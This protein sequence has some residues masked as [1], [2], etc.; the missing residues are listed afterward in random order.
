MGWKLNLRNIGAIAAAPFT[1]GTSLLLAKDTDNNSILNHVTGAASAK[2]ANEQNIALQKETNK[3]SIDLANTAHQREVADLEA[4]GLNPILSAGGSGAATPT[5]GTAQVQNTMPGGLMGQASQAAGILGTIASAKQAASAAELQNAQASAIPSQ[6]KLNQS[7]SA[8]ALA[9]AGYK[10]SEIDYYMEH[11]TFPGQTESDTWSGL[12]F[13]RTK[14][15]PANANSAKSA[16]TLEEKGIEAEN[17][18]RD[19]LRIKHRK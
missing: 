2:K 4:A 9:E 3:M 19:L 7:E 10:Q 12:G 13:S 14:T 11:G 1:A 18:L 6:V 16:K 17:E 8:K 15:R 5:L